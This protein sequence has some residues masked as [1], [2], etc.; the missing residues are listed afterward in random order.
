MSDKIKHSGIINAI[1]GECISVRILQSSACSGCKV[2][3]HCNSSETKEK[4]IEVNQP[5]VQSKYKIGDH[6]VVV[7]DMS[8]GFRASIYGYILPLVLM[9]ATL[10]LVIAC[11][12]GEGIAALSS[13]GILF[14]YYM[15]LFLLK[16]KL[17]EK[18]SFTLE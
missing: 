5:G 2:A 1:R 7:A 18:L 4:I 15:A 10:V 14:P 11:G 8:V 13:L 6:V 12:A 16:D 9:V 17:K 3:S